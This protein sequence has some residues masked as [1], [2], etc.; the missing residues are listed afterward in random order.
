MYTFLLFAC[1]MKKVIVVQKIVNCKL[2]INRIIDD[3]EEISVIQGKGYYKDS[4][5][6]VVFFSTD[7]VNCKYV[8]VD[9]SLTILF[10]D[11]KYIFKKDE[12]GIG[13]IKNGD[14]ILKITTFASKLEVNDSFIVVDYTLY[15]SNVM[16]GKYYSK[17]SFN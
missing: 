11:S 12:E 10:N 15:Q 8:Y 6:I 5:G 17:L 3:K 13:Q 4:E 9:N 7:S 16:I 14:Y 2:E 1:I